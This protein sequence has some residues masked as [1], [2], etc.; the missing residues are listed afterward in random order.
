MSSI[1]RR[2]VAVTVLLVAPLFAQE[3]TG[4]LQGII[5]EASGAVVAHAQVQVTSSALIGSKQVTTDDSGYYRFANLPPGTYKITVTAKGFATAERPGLVIEVGHLPSVDMILQVGATE[6]VVEVNAAP[7]VIDVTTSRTMTNVTEDVI[8]DVPHGRSFQS[9]I[10]FAPSA[11]NEPLAGNTVQ[12]NGSGGSSPGSTTNGQAYGFSVAGGADSENSYLVEGQETANVIGGYSHTNVPFDFIQEVQ[13]KT[14]GV[15]A[16]HGG[17]LGGVVNVVMKKGGNGFHGSV[18]TEYENDSMD[19]SPNAYSRYNPLDSG[20][21]APWGG[22]LDPQYQ[23]YQP[24]KDSL[25]YFTPGFTLSGPIIKDKV[26]FFLGFNP[27]LQKDGRTV[28]FGNNGGVQHFSQNTQSYYTNA[29]IDASL[30]ERVRVFGS[31]LYQYQRR[32][33]EALPD[34]DST[35]GLYNVSTSIPVFAFSHDLGY[36]APNSTT[37][38]GADFTLNQRMIATTR[39]GYYFEN[40]HDFGYPTDGNLYFFEANGVG[41]SDINGNPLPANLQQPSGY[42]N[43]AQNQNYT[44]RNANK[45]IQFDQDFAWFKSGWGG[46]HNFKFGYQLN[47]ASNDIFQRYNEPA[48]QIFPGNQQFYFTAG[49]TGVGNCE[50]L[51]AANGPAYG[52]GVQGSNCTGTYGYAVVQDY[53]SFGKATSYNHAFFVQ[54]S[55]TVGHGVTVNAGLRIEK[56]Y[57]PGETTTGGFPAKPIQ[58]G[59]DDKIAPRLGAAWDVFHDG[60]MKVFG[61][62]GVLN[63]VMKLNL[64]IS[65]FGGQYWQN[66]AYALMTPDY[67]NA[68]NIGFDSN[69]RY[70]TGDTTGGANFAGGTVPPGLIFLENANERSTESVT[71]GLKPYRQHESDFG[72]DYQLSRTLALE[73]RWD[74]RRLDHVIED[75]ALFDS[76]GTEVFTIVNPG[77]GLNATNTTCD[78]ASLLPAGVPLCPPN[79]KPA[80]S[81]D[82]VEIRLTKSSSN[83]WS[84]MFSYTYSSLRGN[85]TGLTSTDIADGGGGRNAPNNSRSFDESYFQFNANGGS[86]SG[87]LP[88]D[89]PNTFKGYAYYDVGWKGNKTTVGIFQYAYQGSPVSSYVDVGYSVIPG[90]YFAV[91]VAGRGQYADLTQDPTTGTITV[92]GIGSRRTP[93]FTQTDF[94]FQESRKIGGGPNGKLSWLGG[95]DKEIAFT[96]TIPNLL[97]Q[98][99][100]TAYNQQIDS[101]QF[102]TFL[103]PGGLPFYYGGQAYSA[104]EHPYNWQSLLNT[105]QITLD[106]QY[107]KP[108]LYQLS[109]NIRLGLKFTF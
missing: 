78:N 30:S 108:Y 8:Q 88:T 42:F 89:R 26:W 72:V 19:G 41:G 18:F 83:H 52:D 74:R 3:T 7:P 47:R 34:A 23:G 76:T 45:H 50:A 73:A 94:N 17:A 43:A 15:E 100:V 39:F 6:T 67:A 51:V 32:S 14:S 65:S 109:R 24:K 82:G 107:G 96:A 28:D 62:Y 16:E 5:K 12:S 87:P 55:W 31:W 56:E 91:Y 71:P 95:E 105:N 80:R 33:G 69:G 25:S 86:S 68:L 63:D 49:S 81:Y 84:G 102:A 54:D 104:Y 97:N 98:H 40:Y 53:G 2:L 101:G 36:S 38:F 29:R 11:R 21:I 48:T 64:A 60:R 106:S 90:N 44:V 10:Q 92:N 27:W 99:A 75:S 70:C 103:Q 46:T 93:W 20:S 66:C 4:G 9:V 79:I 13:I 59:W 77:E 57:L 37:N 85:Y 61:S 58:F 22:Q 35:S 1:L